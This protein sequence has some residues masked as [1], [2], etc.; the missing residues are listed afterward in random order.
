MSC[1]NGRRERLR[2]IEEEVTVSGVGVE[3]AIML[4]TEGEATT[5]ILAKMM[6]RLTTF[7]K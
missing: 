2:I 3:M 7:K 6:V 1:V 4:T 5:K